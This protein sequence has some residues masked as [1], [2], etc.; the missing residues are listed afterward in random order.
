MH[1]TPAA[2]LK[3]C[4]RNSGDY[5]AGKALLRLV[6]GNTKSGRGHHSSDKGSGASTSA[7]DDGQQDGTDR[8]DERVP[9]RR[10]RRGGAERRCHADSDIQSSPASGRSTVSVTYSSGKRAKNG[11]LRCPVPPIGAR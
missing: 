2:A 8:S 6:K 4:M 7:P 3:W 1:D 5:A 11:N 9:H 10:L